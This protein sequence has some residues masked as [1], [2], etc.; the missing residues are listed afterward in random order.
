MSVRCCFAT[1]L[2]DA[3]AL[4][5]VVVLARALAGGSDMPPLV[6]LCR[7]RSLAEADAA[8]LER[9]PNVRLRL[10]VEPPALARLWAL[11]D[12][13]DLVLF[14]APSVLVTSKEACAS[15]FLTRAPEAGEDAVAAAPELHA[16]DAFSPAVSLLRPSRAV[17]ERVTR[18]AEAAGARLGDGTSEADFQVLNACFPRWFESPHRLPV[19]YNAA[20]VIMTLEPVYSRELNA[21]CVRWAGPW[22]PWNVPAL[23]GHE[24]AAELEMKRLETSF[25][26]NRIAFVRRWRE[27]FAGPGN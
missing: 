7:E 20:D 14:L 19:A 3:A 13:A 4:A 5:G 17:E 21:V 25:G 9:E 10:G 16:P 24:N 26:P 27:L 23:I 15:L 6:V 11:E 8:V 22:R 2:E 12:V 18:A 1:V